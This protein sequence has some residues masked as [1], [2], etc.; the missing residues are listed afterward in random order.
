MVAEAYADQRATYQRAIDARQSVLERLQRWRGLTTTS[1]LADLIEGYTGGA[2]AAAHALMNPMQSA[3]L[4]AR[5]V[6]VRETRGIGVSWTDLLVRQEAAYRRER[7]AQCN[8]LRDMFNA[9]RLPVVNPD[10]V[11]EPIATLA[12]EAYGLWDF[13]RLLELREML[14]RADCEDQEMLDHCNQSEH[15]RGCWVLDELLGRR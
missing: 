15:V 12:Q 9:S 10:G 4:A 2:H 1:K 8:I 3:E 11:P 6:A 13:D 7:A 14:S 5:A